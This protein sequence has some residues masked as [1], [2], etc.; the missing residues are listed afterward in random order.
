MIAPGW[1]VDLPKLTTRKQERKIKRLRFSEM[2]LDSEKAAAWEDAKNWGYERPLFPNELEASTWIRYGPQALFWLNHGATNPEDLT[3]HVALDS[4]RK[5]P[6]RSPYAFFDAAYVVGS[7]LGAPNLV[8][9][10][11]QNQ[12]PL[13]DY[14]IRLGWAYSPEQSTDGRIHM[15]Y[16]LGEM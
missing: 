4:D 12:L 16:D 8:A 6:F 7:L 10:L 11:G 9:I 14:L 2:V 5:Y 1:P 15:I 3:L 13:V